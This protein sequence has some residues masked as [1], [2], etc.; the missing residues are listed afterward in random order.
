MNLDIHQIISFFA[1]NTLPGKKE[2]ISKLTEHWDEINKQVNHKQK[3][4][5]LTH[6]ENSGLKIRTL[7]KILQKYWKNL[8]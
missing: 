7:S 2:F 1:S 4:N 6:L 5:G 8:E 3:M